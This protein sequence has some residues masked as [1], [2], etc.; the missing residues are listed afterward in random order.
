MQGNSIIRI[1][2]GKSQIAPICN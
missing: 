1:E 2:D